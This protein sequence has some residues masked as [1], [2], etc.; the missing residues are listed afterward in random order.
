[1]CDM[2]EAMKITFMYCCGMYCRVTRSNIKYCCFR[3]AERET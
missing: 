3:D 2:K 1:M